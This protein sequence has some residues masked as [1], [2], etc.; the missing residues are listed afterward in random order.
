LVRISI[1][2]IF[3]LQFYSAT[4]S[5]QTKKDTT[6]LS[7]IIVKASA[8][9]T[10][11]QNSISTVAIVSRKDID[12]SDGVILSPIFNKVPGI[13]MQ[14]GSLNTNR[15]TIRGIG[16]RA[17]YGTNRIKAYFD[18][19]PLT[20]AEGETD[21]EDIDL[22]TIGQIE[23]IKG[24]N[25]N[26][27][28]SGLGGVIHLSS[29]HNIFDP[30]FV[31]SGIT[32]GS[33]GLFK[34]NVSAGYHDS[35]S[36]LFSNYSHIQSEGYRANSAYDRKAFH[37][38]GEQKLGL[39]NSMS[40]LAIL[41]RLKGYI[42]SSLNITDYQKDP[43]K[44]ANN[45]AAAQGFESY[46]KFLMGLSYHHQ[47]AHHWSVKASLFSN[48]KN[49]FEPRPFDILD[50]ETNYFGIRSSINHEGK[51][52]YRPFKLSLGTELSTEQYHFSLSENLYQLQPNQGSIV[53][54]EFSKI[55]QN[56]SYSNYFLE[57]NVLLSERLHL[58]SGLALNQSK[59]DLQDIFQ[60]NGSQKQRYT[61]GNVCSPRLGFSYQISEGKNL[62]T[63][64]SKGFS[65]PS[66]AET[67]SPEGQINTDLKPEIG[68]NY[69]FGFKANWLNHRIYSEVTL[70]D[71]QIENLLVANST[72]QG[73]YVGVNAGKS[74]HLGLEFLVNYTLL[75]NR[76]L[77]IDSYFSGAV[78]HF[79]F[80]NF[81]NQDIDYSGNRL[82]GAPNFQLNLGL[83]IQTGNGFILN[84]SLRSVGKIPMN[85]SN[86]TYSEAYSLF[87]I[88]ASYTFSFIK[89]IK[90][91]IN[92]GLNN[93]MDKHYA[94][95]I[96]PNA[97]GFG[98]ALP[99][100]YYPGNPR[101]YFGGISLKYTLH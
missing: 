3:T 65:V 77:K 92:I 56:R 95:S 83:D 67:L 91:E 79:R 42:P 46:D 18:E 94:A 2:C 10:S 51:L 40:F 17:Q 33:F 73:Q 49:A 45:W 9:G 99:R 55:K 87:D 53:G 28:G 64:L 25:S 69:E 23:I 26:S 84:T 38:N 89:I 15:I 1:V 24:P 34:Q 100:Y 32:M 93:V 61:F 8:I 39:N 70:F 60:N 19:I 14:Q 29:K 76:Q 6:S 54:K 16:A 13:Y 22:E 81:I 31:K 4:I 75:E 48:L 59:Y 86:T 78:N 21:I 7:E 35:K 37:I 50:D 74:T 101:N 98:N 44:A 66:V 52:F 20:N 62:F 36:T 63:S 11:L 85:D 96:L 72:T 47:L 97:V 68:W 80:N 5:G 90:A 58:E 82:T 57:L 27:F 12:K 88:K 30:L 71:T 43:K 41:T